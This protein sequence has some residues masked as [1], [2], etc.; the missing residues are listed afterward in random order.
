[1]VWFFLRA[2]GGG[3]V[4]VVVEMAWSVK[5]G[6]KGRCKWTGP[7]D[8]SFPKAVGAVGETKRLHLL[9]IGEEKEGWGSERCKG[10]T[11][12]CSVRVGRGVQ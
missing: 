11:G 5:G 3:G 12:L 7:L 6:E 1:M 2:S 8:A 10:W 9:Q 4:A